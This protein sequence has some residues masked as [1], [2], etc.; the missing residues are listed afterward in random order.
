MKKSLRLAVFLAIFSETIFAESNTKPEELIVTATRTKQTYAQTLASVTVFKRADIEKFQ[1]KTLNELLSKAPG[2]SLSRTGARGSSTSVFLRGNQSDHTLFLVDGVRIGSSTLGSSPVELID[3]QLIERIEIVRGPKSSL[4]GSDALGGVINIITRKAGNQTPVTLRAAFGNNKTRESSANIGKKGE[5]YNVN[6]SLS[7]IYTT[8][9]DNTESKVFPSNDED[10]FRQNS[11]GINGK[12]NVTEDLNFTTSY[13][14]NKSETEFDDSCTDATTFSPVL[15]TPFS[16]HDTEA[17]NITAEW[18]ILNNW[19]T[20][21][22]F[23][24]SKDESETIAEEIDILTTFSGGVF[25]TEKTNISWL[26][27]LK[28]HESTSLTLGYDYLREEVS[29][30]TNYDVNERDNHGYFAQL[31]YSQG[32]FSANAGIR[33][34]DNEQFGQHETY[35]VSAGYDFSQ[36]LKVIIS[37]GEAFKAPTF[38]DLY[39]PNFG[40]PT[41]IPE[42]SDT[43]EIALRGNTDSFSWSVSAYKNNVENLIQYNSDIF[44]N[45]QISS[46]TIEGYEFSLAGELLGWEISTALSLTDTEDDATGNELARRAE[47]TFNLDIDRTF[48]DLSVGATFYTSSDSFNN[49]LNTEELNGNGT[50]AIRGAYQINDE[51]KLHFKA[52]NIFEKDYVLARASSFTGLGDYQQAGLEVLFSVVYTPQL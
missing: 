45:D 10:A 16:D 48:G 44:A 50:V 2:I 35:N 9:I 41:M 49:A 27:H 8:G 6:L 5:N 22:S 31:Q 21:L 1:P 26:H 39:F 38:N 25:N 18:A 17:L 11:L 15:C 33:K 30:T 14:L 13:Q 34:D 43:Y 52:D 19:T 7:S 23:G 37:Y 42:E 46:A 32:A 36:D 24:E 28:L 29:G 47:Q 51:W 40:D 20:N 12:I 4:Y 3:P